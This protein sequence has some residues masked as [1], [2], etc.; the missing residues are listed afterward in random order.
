MVSAAIITLFKSIVAITT[1]L[2]IAP[3]RVYPNIVPQNTTTYPCVSFHTILIGSHP[4]FDGA[5]TLDQHVVEFMVYANTQ[6]ESEQTAETIRKGIEDIKGTYAG[7][8]IDG[9]RYKD[10]SGTQWED[11]VQKHIT[12][13]EFTISIQ[14]QLN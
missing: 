3:L 4:S 9:I 13:I 10:S 5:S 11:E 2:G 14:R 7:V 1:V 6:L 12:G 8:L